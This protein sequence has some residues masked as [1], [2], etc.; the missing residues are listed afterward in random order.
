MFVHVDNFTELTKT[1]TTE[2]EAM[3]FLH[4]ISQQVKFEI[5]SMI[6]VY[7]FISDK[8]AINKQKCSEYI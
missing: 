3:V 5:N 7:L 2:F 4:I 1:A 6:L 8:K